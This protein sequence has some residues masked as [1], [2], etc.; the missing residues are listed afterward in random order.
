[1]PA[2]QRS[3]AG[4]VGQRLGPAAAGAHQQ[5]PLGVIA[6]RKRRLGGNAHHRL[7]GGLEPV[8]DRPAP[9]IIDADYGDIAAAHQPLLDLGVVL[10]GAVAVEVIRREVEQDTDA[11]MDRGRK[12]DLVGGALDDIVPRRFR[13][14]E[15]QHGAADIA[16]HLRVAS[17]RRQHMRQKRGGRGFAVGAGNGDERRSRRA[18]RPLAS[19]KL[20]IADDFNAGLVREVDSP[21]RLRIGQRNARRQHEAGKAGPVG[22]AQVTDRYAFAHCGLDAVGIVVPRHHGRAAC[23]ERAGRGDARAAEPEQRDL[24]ASGCGDR[25]HGYLSFSVERPMSA[26]ITAMIQKRITTWLSVQPSFSK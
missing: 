17:G 10:H 2:A 11:R 26:R 7:S 6:V 8:R 1:M 3:D 19:E 16:A 15:R 12:V 20:D 5:R 21:V 24:A 18:R 14:I 4:D 13:R 25:D 22:I 23:H 9:G